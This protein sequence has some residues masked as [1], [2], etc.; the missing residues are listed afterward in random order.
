MASMSRT[1]GCGEGMDAMERG[2]DQGKRVA[3]VACHVA[4]GHLEGTSRLTP[5]GRA[6]IRC[7]EG[8][9]RLGD[10]EDD[11]IETRDQSQYIH[12]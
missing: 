7:R 1:E 10:E 5:S 12:M 4:S 8:G 11:M 2:N 6:G 3:S 9:E